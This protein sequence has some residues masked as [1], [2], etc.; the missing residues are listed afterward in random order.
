MAR[1]VGIIPARYE[2]KRLPGKM[3][4]D[5]GGKP[6]IIHTYERAREAKL[7]D[8]VIVATDDRR[9]VEAVTKA[10]GEAVMTAA[11]HR[12][13]SDRIAEIASTLECD[14]VVNVQGDEALIKPEVIDAAVRLLLDHPKA[15]MGTMACPIRT[16]DEYTDRNVVKVACAQ[17]GEALYFSRAPIPHSKQGR[18]TSGLAAYRHIGLYAFRRDFLLVYTTLPTSSLERA[19]DLEQLRA[20]EH[21]HCIVVGITADHTSLNID[22]P[23]DLEKAREFLCR[24]STS[25]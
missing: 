19:E 3:L 24:K 9:I 16:E 5:L 2:S 22:T 11:G 18:F 15:E 14:V 25:L 10:G 8:R 17:D 23:E 6:L 7:L 13:G 21:G 12:S 20:L 4:L 1:V